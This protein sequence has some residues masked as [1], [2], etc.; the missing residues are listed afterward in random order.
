MAWRQR[1]RLERS[2]CRTIAVIAGVRFRLATQ[3]MVH[4]SIEHLLRQPFL[5]FVDQTAGPEYGRRIRTGQQ[6]IQHLVGNSAF[7][8]QRSSVTPSPSLPLEAGVS[9]DL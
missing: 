3:M 7:F 9:S 5:Q 2:C 6:L 4:L 8:C 1:H